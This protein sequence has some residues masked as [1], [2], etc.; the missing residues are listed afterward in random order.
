MLQLKSILRKS[1]IN[2]FNWI[3]NRKYVYY[4]FCD[5]YNT[6]IIGGKITVKPKNLQGCYSLYAKSHIASRLLI[7][8]YETDIVNI[9]NQLDFIDGTIVNIGAN[10]GLFSV[11]IALTFKNYDK[12]IAIEPNREALELLFDN[13]KMNNVENKIRVVDACISNAH[14][15]VELFYVPEIPEYSSIGSKMVHPAIENEKQNS[16]KVN[17]LKLEELEEKNINFIIID[18]EGAELL[19]LEGSKSILLNNHPILLFECEDRLLKKFNNTTSEIFNLLTPLNYLL[20]NAE[21]GKRIKKFNNFNG[22]ILAI[23]PEKYKNLIKDLK[24]K[25]I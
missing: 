19:V 11:H 21:T 4:R 18:T 14:G 12:I 1:A 22:E 10:I 23:Y 13:I 2:F 6:S 9:I 15:T 24:L 17:M 20:F 8:N 7:S 16:Y 25:G 3:A 5:M